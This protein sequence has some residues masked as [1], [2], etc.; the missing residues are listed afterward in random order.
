MIDMRLGYNERIYITT[1]IVGN[2]YVS[3]RHLNKTY[4]TILEALEEYLGELKKPFVVLSQQQVFHEDSYLLMDK[5]L[6]DID[7]VD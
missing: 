3:V 2:K 5:E 7:M 1:F 6:I 4:S